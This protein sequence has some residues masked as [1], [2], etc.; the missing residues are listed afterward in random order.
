MIATF[1]TIA[2]IFLLILLGLGLRK[3]LMR[4]GAFWGK[5]DRL[6]YWVLMPAL[7]FHKISLAELGATPVGAYALAVLGGFGAAVLYSLIVVRLTG[8]TAAV[9]SSVLQGAARHNSFIA[10]AAA[11]SLYGPEGL[12]IAVLATAFLV[13]ATNLVVVSL[14]VGKLSDKSG[15]QVI[16]DILR[17]L[18]KNPLILGILAGV[19]MN[20]AVDTEVPVL[21][22]TTRLLGAAAL[23]VML[24]SVGANLQL[25]KISAD[26]APVALAFVGKMLVFPAVV[27]V[28]GLW[29]DLP[30]L[31]MQV[32]ICYAAVPTGAS[33]Y[34]LA[35]LL[36]GDAPL[37]AG[38][39]TLQTLVAMI[40]MPLTFVLLA[41]F[42]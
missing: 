10:L 25:A 27:L 38:I 17:D 21:H 12:A 29:L 20:I 36:G 2:P 8:L 18:A 13:P 24:L 11:S 31:V 23:P 6:T 28:L 15:V 4:D 19:L 40:T 42:Y 39:I 26:V 5:T 41:Q 34:T 37:M 14:M 22:E 7:M 9:G 30:V 33:S 35:R 16:P 32:A 3:S 1:V